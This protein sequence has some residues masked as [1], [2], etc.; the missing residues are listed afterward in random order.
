M[1]S[2]RWILAV[3]SLAAVALAAPGCKAWQQVTDSKYAGVS[4]IVFEDA[5]GAERRY[6]V[7]HDNKDAQ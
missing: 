6:L 4:G 2:A 3:F 1:G 5:S 7:V